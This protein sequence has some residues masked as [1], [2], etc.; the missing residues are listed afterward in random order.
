MTSSLTELHAH[1]RAHW[2]RALALWSDYARLS[3]PIWCLDRA[4]AKREGLTSSFAMIRLDDHAVVLNLPEIAARNLG[5]FPL[6]VLGH[7][8]GHH[9]LCPADLTDQGRL[10]ARVRRGLPGREASAPL[11]ANLYAD[12]LINDQLQRRFE[13]RFPEIYVRLGGSGRLWWLYLRI[14]EILWRLAPGSLGGKSLDDGEE[15]D[16][17]L[18]ARL[19]RVYARDW[20]R[21][22]AG[23]AAL[24]RP[25]LDEPQDAAGA[26][27]AGWGD[28]AEA[29]AGEIP[30]GLIQED[31]DEGDPVLHPAEDPA[32]NGE[33]ELAV[34]RS[35]R[36]ARAQDSGGKTRRRYRDLG[37][38][39]ELLRA[40]GVRSKERDTAIR[41]YRERARP[42]LIRFPARVLPRVQE[43]M[44]EGLET[45]DWGRPAEE[46]DWLE[47]L[48]RAPLLIPGYTTLTRTWGQAPG[49]AQAEQVVDLYLGI[50]CSGSMPAPTRTTSFAVLAGFI[51]SLSALRAGARVMACLSGEPGKSKATD[52]FIRDQNLL[53]N[54]LVDYLG[55]GYSYGIQR[56]KE[57]KPKIRRGRR[58]HLLILTDTDIFSSLNSG[59][60]WQVAQRAVKDAGGGATLL[61]ASPAQYLTHFEPGIQRLEAMGWRVARVPDWEGVV[62]FAREFARR[63]YEAKP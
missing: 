27:L 17:Q 57:V 53:F 47:S 23:F 21:G 63:T 8:I 1:W 16:A 56:L 4:C 3:E 34:E 2:P 55:T 52:G 62:A 45:W 61:L 59:D 13:L 51:V 12:L 46:V 36:A 44:P 5:E 22:A 11:V 6:E 39:G 38:Y 35:S 15:G 37:E 41:Y 29:P 25:Y 49:E 26:G 48:T 7:E 60:G 18:G 50:D 10:L 14:Y 54:L 43:P 31:G 33:R 19:V 30:D 42:Y 20:L 58:C 32:L 28:T 9:I 24:C 40:M